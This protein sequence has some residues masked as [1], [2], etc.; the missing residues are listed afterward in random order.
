LVIN[1]LMAELRWKSVGGFVA[2]LLGMLWLIC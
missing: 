2:H 1:G